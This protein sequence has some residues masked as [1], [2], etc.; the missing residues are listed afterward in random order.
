[1]SNILTTADK[2]AMLVDFGFTPYGQKETPDVGSVEGAETFKSSTNIV[3]QPAENCKQ[4]FTTLCAAD[5]AVRDVEWLWHHVFVR[6][7]LN[8]IQG[9]AGIG[10]T[11][12]L[13]AVVAAQ[14][15]TKEIRDKAGRL[16]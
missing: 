8:S 1:M 6:G 11:F 12:L 5:V 13:C 16:V 9:I 3:A 10:K 7:G 2:A 15:I 4:P 14:N